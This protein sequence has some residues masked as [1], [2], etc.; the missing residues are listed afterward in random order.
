MGGTGEGGGIAEQIVEAT[1][2]V[3]AD[4]PAEGIVADERVVAALGCRR[5]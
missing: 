4:G 5:P 2:E 3:I 1:D